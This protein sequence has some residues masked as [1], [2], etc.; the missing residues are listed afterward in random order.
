MSIMNT[1]L[2][3]IQVILTIVFA[4]AGLVKISMPA[5]KLMRMATWTQR[6]PVGVVRFIGIMELLGA[7]GLI[8][9]RAFNVFP[10]TMPLA[11]CGLSLIMVMAT[12]HH[13]NHREYRSI[14]LTL[15]LM[16]LSAYSALSGFRAL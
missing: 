3:V 12:Y 15:I 14:I 8:L 4:L 9:S 10:L 13:I 7:A 1:L 6:F 16:M 11:S 2:T 5:Y